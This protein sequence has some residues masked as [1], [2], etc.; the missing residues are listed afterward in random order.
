MGI[1]YIYFLLIGTFTLF[2][3]HDNKKDTKLIVLLFICL[4][5]WLL[6]G[7]RDHSIGA[8]T[9]SYISTFYQL[10]NWSFDDLL[11]QLPK[12][13][14]PLY[15]IITWLLSLISSDYTV[16]LLGWA[17]FPAIALFLCLK[18]NL[19]NTTEYFEAIL[20]VMMLG[21]Y[22]FFIAG[23][24]QTATI[25]IVLLSYKYL[26]NANLWKF[27]ACIAVG[28]FIHNSIILFVLAYPFRYLKMKWWYITIIIAFFILASTIKIDFIINYSK[29]IFNDRFVAYGTVYN[30]S[31]NNTIFIIQLVLFTI[32]FIKSKSLITKD[33][34]NNLLF[35]LLFFGLFFQSMAGM[36]AEMS[37]ISYYYCIFAIILVPRALQEYSPTNR[38]IINSGFIIVCILLL[39]FVS[40][41]NLPI[42][43]F[44]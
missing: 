21:L 33:P 24:R 34:S 39:L 20:I 36:L 11:H 5:T 9:Q 25:S 27:L 43:K 44:S 22:A 19:D 42:Y 37:R 13:R 6:I 14:E 3:A 8:D 15:Y 29:L 18:S 30:S 26:K 28:Y 10:R 41:S 40:K 23:I 35:V 31:Q 1:Y 4:Y 32:C 2:T 7:L 38:S 16:F 17:A 12:L